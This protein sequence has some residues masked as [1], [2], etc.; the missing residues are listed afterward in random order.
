MEDWT[1]HKLAHVRAVHARFGDTGWSGV[2][3]AS[4]SFY[5]W[6]AHLLVASTLALA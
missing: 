4:I 6:R 3:D 2:A 5:I 1:S